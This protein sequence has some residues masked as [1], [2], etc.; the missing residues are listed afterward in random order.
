MSD[1]KDMLKSLRK[2]RDLSQVELAKKIGVAPTTISMYEQGKR[3]PDFE[4]E[5]KLADFFNVNLDTLRG[6]AHL[7]ILSDDEKLLLKIYRSLP[8]SQ[9]KLILGYA[10]GKLQE[11]KQ[12]E[13]AAHRKAV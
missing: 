10:D 2:E 12:E 11:Q 1:F 5:E 9:K 4:T 13:P 8:D 3:E 6:K 7:P